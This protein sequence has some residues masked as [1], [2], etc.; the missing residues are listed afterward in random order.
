MYDPRLCRFPSVDPL[1][2]DYPWYTPFQF[3]GNN[4]IKFI[5]LDGGEPKDPGT[6][7]G[8]IQ[9]AAVQG[10]NDWGNRYWSWDGSQWA[11]AAASQAPEI[12]AENSK[13]DPAWKSFIGKMSNDEYDSYA[14]SLF[15]SKLAPYEVPNG[16]NIGLYGRSQ[17]GTIDVPSAIKSRLWSE[18]Q[19]E[20][21]PTLK[22]AWAKQ[23]SGIDPSSLSYSLNPVERIHY[24]Y[25]RNLAVSSSS[26]GWEMF[27]GAGLEVAT[28]W[29]IHMFATGQ[30]I[31]FHRYPNSNGGGL[32]LYIDGERSIGFD[33]HRF[34]VGGKKT[35]TFVNRPH[36]DIPDA[37]VKHFPW[38]QIDKA[39]RGVK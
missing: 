23:K 21:M 39:R 20:A 5:D 36:I 3:A 16:L 26:E 32:N 27:T 9:E 33:W 24:R 6:N 11:T 31:S 13:A 19:S 34:K 2:H 4:P 29:T 18:A 15:E 38:H 37:D 22:A 17:D 12:T 7:V 14:G 28:A 25:W 10:H 35:G 1:T 30:S 8:D